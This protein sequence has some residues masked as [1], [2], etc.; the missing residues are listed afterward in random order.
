MGWFVKKSHTRVDDPPRDSPTLGNVSPAADLEAIG[1]VARA[2]HIAYVPSRPWSRVPG[3]GT[4][5]LAY[6]PD[7]LLSAPYWYAG[8]TVLRTPNAVMIATRPAVITHPKQVLEGIGGITAGQLVH[9]PL[10]AL[11]VSA[12]SSEVGE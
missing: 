1:P 6:V 10:V 11:D 7:F 9:Q 5:N 12:T 8:N 2:N 3:V 4:A